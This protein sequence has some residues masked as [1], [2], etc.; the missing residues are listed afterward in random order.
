MSSTGRSRGSVVTP[1]SYAGWRPPCRSLAP[2]GFSAKR[3]RGRLGITSVMGPGRS[4][5]LG[6]TCALSV[7]VVS[8]RQS[9]VPKNPTGSKVAAA[10]G[11]IAGVITGED[12]RPLAGA[13]VWVTRWALGNR[14]PAFQVT[15][16]DGGFAFRDL[17]PFDN[18]AVVARKPGFL[19][20]SYG[21][22]GGSKGIAI[23]VGPGETF[24]HADIQL[25]RLGSIAGRLTDARG[26]AIV[27]AFI[28][29]IAEVTVSGAT[30]YAI[31]AQTKTDDQGAY[32]LDG[33]APARYYVLV[34]SVQN[35]VPVAVDEGH[36][37]GDQP[38]NQAVDI[39]DGNR[40]RI[41]IYPR[42]RDTPTTVF[43]PTFF[44]GVTAVTEAV[45][46]DIGFGQVWPGADFQLKTVTPVA[47]RGALLGPPQATAKV[48]VRL[49][50][51][52]LEGLGNGAEAAVTLSDP[53]GHFAFPLVPPGAYVLYAGG[54]TGSSA[55]RADSVSSIELPRAWFS[56]GT[57]TTAFVSTGSARLTITVLQDRGPDL[58][59]WRQPLIIG[60]ESPDSMEVPPQTASSMTG[61]LIWDSDLP[62]GPAFPGRILLEPSTAD[63]TQGLPNRSSLNPTLTTFRIDGIFP[64]DYVLSPAGVRVKSIVWR[65]GDYVGRPFT[66]GEADAIDDVVVTLTTATNRITGQVIRESDKAQPMAVIAFSADRKYWSAYGLSPARIASTL[67]N[68]DGYYRIINLPAGEYLVSAVDASEA[69]SW[70]IPGFL[71][72]LVATAT[73]CSIG[74]NDQRT[75]NLRPR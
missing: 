38:A 75:V 72:R 48:M 64:G 39:G 2:T 52:G 51:S 23:S 40:L 25:R 13:E 53:G 18:Y 35:T 62:P 65:G 71:D 32:V 3:F 1:G 7:V 45:G 28:R 34:P 31:S 6:L 15:G 66:I 43:P 59:H 61:R 41:G 74:W 4:V 49:F 63:P 56:P 30:R 50:P 12:G 20:A 47:V 42:P 19:S 5:I 22:H 37:R 21:S 36:Q 54:T 9:P 33:L 8:A 58:Y 16:S 55:W 57:Q 17:A 70:S 44:P 73:R 60:T 67:A 69:D 46:I 27:G 29:A 10:S 11:S 14:P 24:A 26:D 68:G